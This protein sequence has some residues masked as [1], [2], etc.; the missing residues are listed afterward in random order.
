MMVARDKKRP[1]NTS[2]AQAAQ[3]AL[4]DVVRAKS[5]ALGDFGHLHARRA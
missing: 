2:S 1:A 5:L 4:L 3:T